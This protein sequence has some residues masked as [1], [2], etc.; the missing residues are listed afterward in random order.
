MIRTNVN[1]GFRPDPWD[2]ADPQYSS[3]RKTK[4]LV[5]GVCCL[6]AAV[7]VALKGFGVL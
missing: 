1:G 7:L 6:A 4:Y 2:V 5:V 3:V